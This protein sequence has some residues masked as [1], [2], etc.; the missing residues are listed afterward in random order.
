MYWSAFGEAVIL[1][2]TWIS[3][4]FIRPCFSEAPRVIVGDSGVVIGLSLG[5]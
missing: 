1:A 2:L 3:G 4:A 5:A